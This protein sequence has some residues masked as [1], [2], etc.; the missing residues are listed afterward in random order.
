MTSIANVNTVTYNTLI[1]CDYT[2]N[3]SYYNV[4]LMD[5]NLRPSS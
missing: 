4:Y 1:W 5:N 3:G 2:T